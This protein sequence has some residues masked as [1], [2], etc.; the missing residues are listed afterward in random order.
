MRGLSGK[1]SVMH[2]ANSSTDLP[3]ILVLAR[4]PSLLRRVRGSLFLSL[5][6]EVIPLVVLHCHEALC[7]LMMVAA[8][9]LYL[10][11]A[12]SALIPTESCGF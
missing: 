1:V 6:L 10:V 4:H 5:C 8:A 12:G 9:L 7:G 11:F 3:I 2:D